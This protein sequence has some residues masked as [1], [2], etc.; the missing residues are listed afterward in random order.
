M[1]LLIYE[2]NELDFRTYIKNP[3]PCKGR[4]QGEGFLLENSM[5]SIF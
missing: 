5:N 1:T 4:G 2:Q 3:L